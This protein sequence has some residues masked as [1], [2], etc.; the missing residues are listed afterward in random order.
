MIALWNLFSSLFSKAQSTLI[1]LLQSRACFDILI[2]D[3]VVSL[4]LSLP[5]VISLGNFAWNPPS[6]S[7]RKPRQNQLSRELFI[8]EL[9]GVDKTRIAGLDTVV[10]VALFIELR[11]WQFNRP[12]ARVCVNRTD[13]LQRGRSDAVRVLITSGERES[14]LSYACVSCHSEK[15][16]QRSCVAR[17]SHTGTKN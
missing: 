1:A 4:S 13:A 5:L 17:R 10:C 2:Y 11:S 6:V 14:A 8:D 9:A 16:G 3:F 15:K 7:S 12:R